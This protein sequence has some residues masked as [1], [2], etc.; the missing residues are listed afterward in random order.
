MPTPPRLRLDREAF[1]DVALEAGY[2]T[3]TLTIWR[4]TTFYKREAPLP[5]PDPATVSPRIL[6]AVDSINK[7]KYVHIGAAFD[8]TGRMIDLRAVQNADGPEL[9]QDALRSVVQEAV[10]A[11]LKK[12]NEAYDC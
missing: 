11:E 5:S 3:A 2:P 8:K 12:W 4:I 10:S 1:R 7:Q 9:V 6:R